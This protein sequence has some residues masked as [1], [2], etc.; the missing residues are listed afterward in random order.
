MKTTKAIIVIP[1]RDLIARGQ[2]A[3]DILS[4]DNTVDKKYM[5]N[6]DWEIVLHDTKFWSKELADQYVKHWLKVQK[7]DS[8][9]KKDYPEVLEE[10]RKFLKKLLL[11]KLES[12]IDFF[13]VMNK[14]NL[15]ATLSIGEKV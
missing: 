15:V 10:R 5:E 3:I 12:N 7:E 2:R 4:V 1:S 11:E 9:D 8:K 6:I 13:D 14:G